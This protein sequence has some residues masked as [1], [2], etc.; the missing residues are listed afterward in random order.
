[1]ANIHIQISAVGVELVLGTY[2]P[3]DTFIF[4]DWQEFYR[5][6]DIIHSA[7]IIADHV[8]NIKITVDGEVLYEGI[9][10]HN[11]FVEQKSFSPFLVP[12]SLYLRTECVEECVCSCTFE[13]DIFELDK[14]LFETQDY[15]F[16]F[17][18]SQKFIN[19]ITYNSVPLEFEW[20][21]KKAIGNICL[22]CRYNAGYLHPLYDAVNKLST[23][24]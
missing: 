22:L 9:I 8:K 2:L 18:V 16:L 23:R 1:M 20:T 5:Y 19:K 21:A 15:D 11:Q 4:S 3:H 6:N 13:S 7:H 14:L 17:K 10:P 24:I 12:E